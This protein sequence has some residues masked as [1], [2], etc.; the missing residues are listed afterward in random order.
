MIKMISFDFYN[1]LVKFWP[2][3]EEIQ[4]GACRELGISVSKEAI[5]R[6]YAEADIFF[7]RE[8]EDRPLA[9]RSEEDRLAFF[10]RY[11][12]MI[13]EAA[14]VRVSSDLAQQIWKMAMTVPKDFTLFDD[15]IPALSQLAAK[16]FSLGLISNLRRDMGQLCQRLGMAEYLDFYIN[17][18]EVGSEKPHAPIFQAA[19]ERTA[20]FPQEALHIGDQY[21]SDVLGAKAVGMH[22]VLIDRGGWS[23]EANDCPIISSLSDLVGLLDRAP[24]SLLSQGKSAV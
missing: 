5:A 8:N 24:A 14:G 13:L 7:N 15:A 23:T 3:L 17:S 1:T 10:G 20:V 12:Q 16:G 2:A 21:R 11:E 6:G 9:D 4:H 22:A 18:E 19:L